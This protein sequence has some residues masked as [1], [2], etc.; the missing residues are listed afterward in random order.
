MAYDETCLFIRAGIT[1]KHQVQN[2]LLLCGNCH[3]E[4]DILKRYVDVVDDKLVVKVVNETNDEND[5]NYKSATKGLKG[6]RR[7]QLEF[8]PDN[9]QPIE[10]NGEMALYFVEN[11]PNKL[12]NRNA[13]EF[14]KTACM[15]WRMGGGAETDD[16]YC[17]DDEDVGPVDTAALKRRFQ[18]QDSAETLNIVS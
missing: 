5:V 4:F 17:S 12:P 7:D 6:S 18:I 14:H 13:L 1:Q 11:Y 16:E 3:D 10:T 9:R 2:G 15:I 8:L